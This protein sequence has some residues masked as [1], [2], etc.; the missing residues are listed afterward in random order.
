MERGCEISMELQFLYESKMYLCAQEVLCLKKLEAVICS[1]QYQVTEAKPLNDLFAL[2]SKDYCILLTT[3]MHKLT[4]AQENV[5][6]K[7]Y[8]LQNG[9]GWEY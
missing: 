9:Q 4:K 8:P 1:N 2:V 3:L 6:I 7:V 5:Y